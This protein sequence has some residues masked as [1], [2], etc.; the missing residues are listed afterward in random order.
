MNKS[1]SIYNALCLPASDLEAL[2]QGRIIAAIPH[3]LLTPGQKFALYP[4]ETSVNVLSI[5]AWAKCELCQILDK[6]KPLDI[7]S[8]LTIWK[9]ERFEEIL[10]K[11]PHFFL[12]YLRVYHL[13][14]PLEIPAIPNIQDKLGK[15]VSLPNISASEDKPV[16]SNQIFI[17]R[18]YQL[19][20]L[21]PPLHPELEELQSAL[22]QI[23]NNNPAAQ[24]LEN[25]IKIFLGWS[26][27]P[28]TNT[29]DADLA[30][31]KT[32]TTLGDRSIELEEKKSN[33]QAGT[34]FEN[35]SRQSLEFLG[36]KVET[37][38]KGGA[39][40]LDLYCSQP[41]PL[42]CECKAGKS[43]PSG[44][45]E[46]LIKLGGMHLGADKFLNSPKLVIGPG[47]ATSDNLKSSKEWKVSIIKAMT[48]QKL[49]ELKAKYP[50][51]INLIELKQ[52]L[53]PGQIDDKINEYIDKIEKEIKLRSHIIQVLK[54]Y[55]QVSKNE[56]IGVEALH[57]VYVTS[58]PPQNLED[59]ELYD[60][61][62]ELSSPLTGYLGRIKEDYWKKDRF[63]YLRDLPIN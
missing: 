18:K 10:Q 41:Y 31:I 37:A 29:I 50:G 19:E 23:A 52:Y 24:Q 26:N 5:K 17:Q 58:N 36:F 7:L 20:N 4:V 33:Y 28:T 48:L 11:H 57:A 63:Y 44:T 54:N 6:N 53:E 49:V 2:I 45:V 15:F 9:P 55:L 22:S 51:A 30:W 1:V 8:Q 32:I 25:E 60:I 46:E 39:G 47:N 38:Y 43:I 3:K 34:D 27:E 16:L 62:I 61:L 56:R 14:K 35:I 59:R 12:A 40:G 42:V 21:Q 13:E